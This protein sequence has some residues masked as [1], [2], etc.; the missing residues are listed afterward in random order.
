MSSKFKTILVGF[1]KISSGYA[2]DAQMAK[3]MK[4]STHIQVLKEHP[5]FALEAVVD[6]C[7]EACRQA[8]DEWG[9]SEVYSNLG[10]IK[11]PERFEVAVIASPPE[12]RSE[13]FNSLPKLKGVLLEKPIA[14]DFDS[15][16]LFAK[17]LK[18]RKLLCQI[19]LLRRADFIT[20]KLAAG[21]LSEDLGTIQALFG[22]YGNGLINNGTHMIDL[23]RMLCG[24]V[25]SVQ[26]NAETNSFEEGPIKNDSNFAFN[27]NL[28][29]GIVAN[30]QPIRFS[31]YRENGIELWGE[32]GRLEYL[33]GGLTLLKANLEVNKM[34][35]DQKQI[36]LDNTTKIETSLGNAMYQMYENLAQALKSNEPLFSPIESALKTAEVVDALLQ[37]KRENGRLIELRSDI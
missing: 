19:N 8:K 21:K 20:R 6:P 33:H 31:A 34:H 1:G 29:S 7:T 5:D 36:A 16:K 11:E 30:F 17:K 26:S 15:A 32:K 2:S 25:K 28:K 14:V 4:F 22:V 9:V 13:I 35:S 12:T 27:L 10:A 18:E 23:V 3:N 24:E 37:S